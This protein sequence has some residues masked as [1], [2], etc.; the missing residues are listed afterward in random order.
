MIIQRCMSFTE[1]IVVGIFFVKVMHSGK[2]M[3]DCIKSVPTH[4]AAGNDLDHFLKCTSCRTTLL[5]SKLLDTFADTFWNWFY[6]VIIIQKYSECIKICYQP[7]KLKRKNAIFCLPIQIQEVS[8]SETIGGLA[9]SKA[10]RKCLPF[11]E[12]SNVLFHES[13]WWMKLISLHLRP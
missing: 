11:G 3:T 5:T 12:I 8:A 7:P 1:K 6:K 10:L 13:S 4:L 2:V 9:S